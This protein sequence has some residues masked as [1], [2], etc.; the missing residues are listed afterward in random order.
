[1]TALGNLAWRDV[2]L[3]ERMRSTHGLID[4]LVCVLWERGGKGRES[5]LAALAN[6]TLSERYALVHIGIA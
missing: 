3:R 1:V 6:L 2:A 4:A 5:A